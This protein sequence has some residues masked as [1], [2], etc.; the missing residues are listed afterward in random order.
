MC[1]AGVS[2]QSAYSDEIHSEY[3]KVCGRVIGIGVH[4]PDAF[5]R[6]IWFQT[7]I[8]HNYLDGVSVTHGSP[9]SRAHINFGHLLVDIRAFALVRLLLVHHLFQE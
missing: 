3:S 5:T 8:E 1:G 4:S 6:F 2:C 9:G 7:T